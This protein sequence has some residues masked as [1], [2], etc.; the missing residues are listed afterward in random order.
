MSSHFSIDS[1]NASIIFNSIFSGKKVNLVGN[2]GGH[3]K[4]YIPT[5]TL[6]VSLLYQTINKKISKKKKKMFFAEYNS[7]NNNIEWACHT[8][9]SQVAIM[10]S[11]GSWYNPFSNLIQTTL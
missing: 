4:I 6:N 2:L 3:K 7:C 9:I 5:H 10:F 1:K 8:V 11:Q